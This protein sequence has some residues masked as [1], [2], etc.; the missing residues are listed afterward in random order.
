LRAK[1]TDYRRLHDLLRTFVRYV[2]AS[3]MFVYGIEKLF[4]LQFWFPTPSA[5]IETYADS[6]P[7]GILWR[8][9]GTSAVYTIFTGAVETLGVVLLL[10]RRTTTLGALVLASALVNVVALNVGYGIGVKFFAMQLLVL[11]LFLL[12]PE[13]GR[14]LDFLIRHRT[15]EP[16][17]LRP[18]PLSRR[19]ELARRV[20]KVVLVCVVGGRMTQINVKM[21]LRNLDTGGA[22]PHALWGV[23]DVEEFRRDGQLVP[24]LA[25]DPKL[26][27]QLGFGDDW[28]AD[29]C[30]V[31][32]DESRHLYFVDHD[33]A[34]G[35]LTISVE[36]KDQKLT[37]RKP[38]ATHLEIE[39]TYLG[40]HIAVRL[41]LRDM[42]A[43]RIFQHPFSWVENIAGNPE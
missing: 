43:S 7:T 42:S 27:H 10:W 37:V 9:T 30:I 23:Y 18:F 15:V 22:T 34:K 4:R 11:D 31:A 19:A 35:T 13:A 21:L 17:P 6:S 40:D 8:A 28:G 36:D 3:I 33:E 14:L 39:G 2:L 29:V 16:R 20:A 32:M 26:W 38:D 25:G 24:L 12:A 5:L 41:R 1:A